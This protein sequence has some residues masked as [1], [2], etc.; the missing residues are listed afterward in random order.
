MANNSRKVV[1]RKPKLDMTKQIDVRPRLPEQKQLEP[2]KKK[3]PVEKSKP[4]PASKKLL[5]E[6]LQEEIEIDE[7]EEI[8]EII[9]T[10]S[11]NKT[12][13]V[14]KDPILPKE[15]IEFEDPQTFDEKFLDTL[16]IRSRITKDEKLAERLK[17]PELKPTIKNKTKE[18]KK[19]KL[20]PFI[21]IS[22]LA[23]IALI[24]W[25]YKLITDAIANKLDGSLASFMYIVSYC[26]L[27]LM[28]LVWFIIE[29]MKGDIKNE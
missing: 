25:I 7:P 11:P 5:P 16:D 24:V 12:I 19:R 2:E 23:F 14:K 13:I 1:L 28:M 18:K 20:N 4:T 17:K 6:P 29:V 15:F 10:S 27:A 21:F 9:K 22:L 26:L 3:K 8:Q